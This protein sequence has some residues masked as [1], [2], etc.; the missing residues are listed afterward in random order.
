MDQLSM[1]GA[2]SGIKRVETTNSKNYLPHWDTVSAVKELV[3]NAVYAKTVLGARIKLEY[4]GRLARISDNGPG[5][6]MDKLLVGNSEQRES[7]SSPGFFGEG[8]KMSLLIA[9]RTNLECRFE[10]VGF[11]VEGAIEQGVLGPD[12]FIMYV[13]PNKRKRGT[14]FSIECSKEEF[15][16]ACK[17]FAVLNGITTKQVAEATLLPEMANKVFVAGVL[18][19]EQDSLWGY[20]LMDKGLINRDRSTVDNGLLL[21]LVREVLTTISKPALAE[22]LLQALTEEHSDDF[23]EEDACLQTTVLRY[24]VKRKKF[25]KAAARRVF[26]P[27][28]CLATGD[29]SDTTARYKGFKL[30]TG[31]KY[32]WRYF[33]ESVLDIPY[34]RDIAKVAN[35]AKRKAVKLTPEERKLLG[36]YK[37]LIKSFYADPGTVKVAENL[38]NEFDTKIMGCCEFGEVIWLDRSV[39]INEKDLF[40]TLL[41]ETNHKTSGARD[42]STEF[43]ETWE[44]I[45]WGLYNSKQRRRTRRKNPLSLA[46][47]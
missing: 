21:N 1:F 39:L 28:I 23:L 20:N 45:C 40:K 33:F 8:M 27:K 31:L 2:F 12:T 7:E 46:A 13:R 29:D 15:E 42:N 9:A 41:H 43:T 38:R 35:K 32:D 22:K 17:S 16:E 14:V 4:D 18:V 36:R 19:T 25:W 30:L 26:G 11:S 3:Q 10:T 5:F 34:S 44:N 6:S 24:D 47:K 37:R